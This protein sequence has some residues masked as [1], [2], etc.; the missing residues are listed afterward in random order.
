MSL[1]AIGLDYLPSQKDSKT[2]EI[3]KRK[4]SRFSVINLYYL[5][6]S[7]IVLDYNSVTII[8]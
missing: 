7:R 4:A 3:Q 5:Y 6:F 2:K 8:T 1:L